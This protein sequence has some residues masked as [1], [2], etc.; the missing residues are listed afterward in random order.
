[1]NKIPINESAKFI[2]KYIIENAMPVSTS[3]LKYLAPYKNVSSLIPAPPIEIGNNC[4]IE[5][6]INIIIYCNIACSLKF[7][8]PFN[9]KYA[10]KTDKIWITRE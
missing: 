8:I 6:I 3:I 2:T 9:I 5:E 1:M 7:S 4:I 10:D